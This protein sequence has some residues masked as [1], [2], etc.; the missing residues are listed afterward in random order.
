MMLRKGQ[1][2]RCQNPRCAAEIKVTKD[3]IE[4]ESTVICCCGAVM[5]KPY[6]KP[7]LKIGK[8]GG[9]TPARHVSQRA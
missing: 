2:L 8:T 6:D 9:S 3:S 5:K 4:G 1:R 7:V